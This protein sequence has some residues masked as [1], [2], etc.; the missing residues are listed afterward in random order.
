[1]VHPNVIRNCGLDP[2]KYQGFAF[3]MGLD[4]I[5][6]LKYGIPDLRAF[7]AAD[8]RWLKH[9]GFS[10]FDVPTLAGGTAS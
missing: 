2:E 4:R 9:F 1:M 6:M 3:G 8:L 10:A 5:A 7:F